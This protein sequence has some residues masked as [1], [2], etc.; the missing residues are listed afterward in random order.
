MKQVKVFHFA[1][2]QPCYDYRGKRIADY[3][4]VYRVTATTIDGA[5]R[6]LSAQL[7][8]GNLPDGTIQVEV[9]NV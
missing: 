3:S 8:Q 4:R 9:R 1:I 5:K 7:G 6:Y 2:P